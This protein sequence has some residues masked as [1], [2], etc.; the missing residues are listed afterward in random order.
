MTDIRDITL[1]QKSY[2][3]RGEYI[4]PNVIR[5]YSRYVHV[6][7]RLHIGYVSPEGKSRR[8]D[9]GPELPGPYAYTYPATICITENPEMS[10]AA[11]SRR[12]R[13]ADL[14]WDAEHGDL[15]RIDGRIYRLTD[16]RLM[17]YPTLTLVEEDA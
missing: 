12:N 15:F 10:T 9:F 6:P 7:I 11:E 4:S 13:D 1:E 8:V 16:D 17:D 5:T 14:E 3:R 2:H